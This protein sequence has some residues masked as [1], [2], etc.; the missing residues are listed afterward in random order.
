MGIPSGNIWC[1]DRSGPLLEPG[2]CV[3]F[4]PQLLS[5]FEALMFYLYRPQY[6]SSLLKYLGKKKLSPKELKRSER[7]RKWKERQAGPAADVISKPG[8]ALKDEIHFVSSYAHSL[9]DEGSRGEKGWREG[10]REREEKTEREICLICQKFFNLIYSCQDAEDP[11][12]ITAFYLPD[13]TPGPRY[14]SQTHTQN[15]FKNEQKGRKSRVKK[16]IKSSCP[17]I[18]EISDLMGCFML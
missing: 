18:S 8:Q 16:L 5:G 15:D 4:I 17:L 12:L 11:D 13:F 2:K 7:E 10:W 9:P 14:S 1:A 6:G 3:C